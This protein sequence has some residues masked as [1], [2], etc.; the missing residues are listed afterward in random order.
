MKR[1]KDTKS[2][3][4]KA[5]SPRVEKPGAKNVR[6]LGLKK[7]K[8]SLKTKI[9]HSEADC[10]RSSNIGQK[11]MDSRAKAPETSMSKS[12]RNHRFESIVS[13]LLN[14]DLHTFLP[15]TRPHTESA[16]FLVSCV[17]VAGVQ[18]RLA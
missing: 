18:A 2:K 15:L 8:K 14:V 4:G 9:T 16:L 11:I 6:N 3:G 17:P 5:L 12:S 1:A 10:K 7:K 13:D